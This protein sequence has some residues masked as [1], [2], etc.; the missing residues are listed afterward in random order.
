VGSI[1]GYL[2]LG[3]AKMRMTPRGLSQPFCYF[4]YFLRP[5]D[6]LSIVLMRILWL[7]GQVRY[8]CL[9][10][11]VHCVGIRL[12]LASLNLGEIDFKRMFR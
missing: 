8:L 5:L 12:V 9:R 11:R 10:I 3:C 4:R 7:I 6:P 2:A 1:F